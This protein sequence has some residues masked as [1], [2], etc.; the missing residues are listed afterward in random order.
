MQKTY[1]HLFNHELRVDDRHNMS[2]TASRDH[3]AMLL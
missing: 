1:L 2:L 3:V